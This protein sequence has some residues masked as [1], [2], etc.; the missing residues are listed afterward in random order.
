MLF[1]CG[2]HLWIDKDLNFFCYKFK[3]TKGEI[4]RYLLNSPP[5]DLARKHKIKVCIGNGMRDSVHKGFSKR[6]N[7]KAVEIFGAT[8]GNCMLI[9][10]TG[11]YGACG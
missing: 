2:I 9:N 6:F 11:K 8:E 7:I 5:S 10:I 4:C 1:L 3:L